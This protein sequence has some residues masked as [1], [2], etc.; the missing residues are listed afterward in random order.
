[1]HRPLTLSFAFLAAF[2]CDRGETPVAKA[3]APVTA[4][5][6][7]KLAATPQGAL[8]GYE[9]LRAL[10]AADRTEGLAETAAALASSSKGAAEVASTKSRPHLEALSRAA[11]ALERKAGDLDRARAAFGEVSRHVVALLVA[12]PDLRK[13]LHVFECPMAE[14]YQKWVQ[15]TTKL[16]NPYMGKKMLECGAD[17]EWKV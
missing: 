13:G 2:A 12:E 11:A 7:P 17:S 8:D 10:L 5:A 1:M 6:A 14:G 16:E 15:R 4:S 3:E 9:S